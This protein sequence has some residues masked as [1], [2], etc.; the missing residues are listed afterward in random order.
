[1]DEA[2]PVKQ[3]FSLSASCFQQHQQALAWDLSRVCFYY[4]RVL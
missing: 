1:M 2:T 3:H 4:G